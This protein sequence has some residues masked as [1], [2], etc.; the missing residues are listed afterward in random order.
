MSQTRQAGFFNPMGRSGAAMAGGSWD[1]KHGH[2]IRRHSHT[3]DQVL[4]AS[5]GV[6]TVDTLEGVW[7][8]PPLRA[9][10]IPAET[11]HG[12]RMSG[13]VSMRTLY[14]LPELCRSLPRKC[15]VINISSL[16]RELILHACTFP[17][18]HQ[19]VP[20]ERHVIDLIVDQ[21]KAVESIPLQLPEPSDARAKKLVKRLFENPGDPRPLDELSAA[22]GASKRTMQRLFMEETGMP[23]SKW[24][25]RLCLITAMQR[26]A[27]GES[28][29]SAALDAGYST[30]SAF[31]SMFRR[32]LG[33]TP[34]RYLGANR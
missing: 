31:I 27:A 19:R 10:W 5:E 12:V 28:V 25:Q 34:G 13:R 9:V 21:L 22:C 24:R 33:T 32:E 1:L 11:I 2:V 4:F 8:V 29:T 15:L 30:T 17:R 20:S 3:E 23:F 26:L 7:V 18:L 14:L 6:M 16:L